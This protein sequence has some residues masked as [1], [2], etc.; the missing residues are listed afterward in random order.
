MSRPNVS[1]QR[2]PQILSA[3]AQLFSERGFDAASM[4]ELS[5]RTGLSKAAIYHYFDGK[6]A[7]IKA[8]IELLFAEVEPELKRLIDDPSP[9][10]DRVR[11]YV[12]H[13]AATLTRDAAML[14]VMLESFARASRDESLFTFA[15]N[16]F[17]NYMRS[18]GRIIEQGIRSGELPATLDPI[19]TGA[20]LVTQIEGCI[21]ISFVT[22]RPIRELLATHVALFLKLLEK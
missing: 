22:R 4:A 8:L 21:L 7:L 20:A 9:A 16:S 18:F 2:I 3:A 5:K 10:V 11:T 6:E 14:P 15:A 1:K 13:L 19:A 12:D 17:E